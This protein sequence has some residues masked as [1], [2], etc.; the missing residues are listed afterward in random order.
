M[1]TILGTPIFPSTAV[2]AGKFIIGDFGH[3]ATLAI[4]EDMEVSFSES[5]SDNFVKDLITVKATE[6]IAL[7]I[8]N[9]NAFVWGTFADAIASLNA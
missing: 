4:R 3:G 5:H 6:R 7:P 9:P 1:L 2:T 8:H